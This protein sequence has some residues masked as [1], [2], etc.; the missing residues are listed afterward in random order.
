[1]GTPCHTPTPATNPTPG[2]TP[3]PLGPTRHLT[4]T[5]ARGRQLQ[6]PR[7]TPFST[8][9]M[10]TPCHTPTPATNPTPGHTPIPLGPTRHLTITWA[11]GRQK[12]SPRP[13]PFSTRRMG[14]PCHTPTPAT[15]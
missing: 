8:R 2:H 1:M 11:R 15:N 9:R 3:I 7:L 4:I 5:W 13:T 6:S 14:T 10:G 12:L